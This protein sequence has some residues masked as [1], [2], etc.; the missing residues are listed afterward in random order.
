MR[1]DTRRAFTAARNRARGKMSRLARAQRRAQC[2]R[3]L[4]R[5]LWLWDRL[6]RLRLLALFDLLLVLVNAQHATQ[7]AMVFIG[8]VM[9]RST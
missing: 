1:A 9:A 6:G 2:L 5:Q 7:D 8:E 4:G 3:A